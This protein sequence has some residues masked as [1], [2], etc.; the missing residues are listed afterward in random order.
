MDKYQI[1]TSE[2]VEVNGDLQ[3]I[4]IRTQN[5]ENPVLLFLHGGPGLCDRHAILKSQSGLSDTFTMVMWDQ[6]GSGKSI[7]KEKDVQAYNVETF[8]EDTVSM[9]AY[10]YEKFGKKKIIVSGHSWGSVLG[11]MAAARCPERIAA[12]IGVG[13]FVDGVKNEEISYRFCMEEA[14][15]RGDKKAVEEL[16]KIP[17]KGGIYPGSGLM[18]QRAYVTRYGGGN[19]KQRDNGLKAVVL[20]LVRSG[21]YKI[22][23]VIPYLRGSMKITDVLWEKLVK[24]D[25]V[26]EISRLEVPVLI[27]SGRHDYQI[28]ATV[29]E[30]WY[31]KLEAPCKEW[32]WFEESAHTPQHEE[33]QKWERTVRD[34]W[35]N[36]EKEA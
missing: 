32:V 3:N 8:I 16:K 20:P 26:K 12:Y 28:P 13:Q 36:L 23:E 2:W 25:W 1:D 9:V 10:L 24:G 35:G 15:R 19:W 33:P 4:R 14:M 6:R 21:E 22:R 17:P 7:H 5:I 30:A 18:T 11:V 34:F 29:A 31:E 27:T